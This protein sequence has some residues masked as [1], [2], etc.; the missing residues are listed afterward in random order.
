M[1]HLSSQ[2]QALLPAFGQ[3]QGVAADQVR[4]LE[5]VIS[6]SPTLVHQ[7]NAAVASGHLTEFQL[8][9]AGTHAGGED[10]L[11]CEADSVSQSFPRRRG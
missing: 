4:N 1:P 5:G 8:L 3:Q 11:S 10:A 6:S 9:P 7:V 2:P